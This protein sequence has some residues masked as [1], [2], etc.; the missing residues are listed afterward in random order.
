MCT[1]PL[2]AHILSTLPQ[3]IPSSPDALSF[4][5]IIDLPRIKSPFKSG[6]KRET[7]KNKKS[8]HENETESPNPRNVLEK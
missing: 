3:L 8:Q 7:P 2:G 5:Y 6:K 1:F 4:I